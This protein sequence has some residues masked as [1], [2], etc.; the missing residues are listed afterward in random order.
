MWLR[1]L[2]YFNVEQFKRK[3]LQKKTMDN[4]KILFTMSDDMRDF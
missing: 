4:Y 1:L 3:K 2:I